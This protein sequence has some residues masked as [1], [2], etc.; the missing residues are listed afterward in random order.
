MAL[1]EQPTGTAEVG[2]TGAVIVVIEA[3]LGSAKVPRPDEPEARTVEFN[4][5]M[6]VQRGITET[7]VDLGFAGD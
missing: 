6:G 7:L 2:V 5:A 1:F 3:T 4:K